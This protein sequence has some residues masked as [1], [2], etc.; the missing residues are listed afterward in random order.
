MTVETRAPADL[1]ETLAALLIAGDHPTA[2][3][4]LDALRELAWRR[5]ATVLRAR[6]DAGPG[7]RGAMLGRAVMRRKPRTRATVTGEASDPIVAGR[8]EA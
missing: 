5:R 7:P 4:A 6:R 1:T 3:W 8:R 2:E